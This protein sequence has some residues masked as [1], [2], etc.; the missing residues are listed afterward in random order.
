MED[1]VGFDGE[2]AGNLT[3]GET[4]LYVNAKIWFYIT[5]KSLTLGLQTLSVESL[6]YALPLICHAKLQAKRF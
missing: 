2:T 4:T 1:T 5:S 3:K 6:H